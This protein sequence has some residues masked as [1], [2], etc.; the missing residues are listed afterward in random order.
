MIEKSFD[1]PTTTNR[2]V[3]N[4]KNGHFSPEISQSRSILVKDKIKM[5]V[6]WCQCTIFSYEKTIYDLFYELF[7]V[8]S[9]HVI[10][11]LKGLYGYD[12]CYSYKD[13][14]IYTSS[15]REDMGIHIL[16]SGT[17]C[18]QVEDLKIGFIDLFKKIRQYNAHYTRLDIAI[19][20]FTNKY[21]SMYRVKKS[22]KDNC[23]VS[24]FRNTIEFIKTQIKDSSNKGYTI[25]F[26]SRASDIQIVFYDKLKER[27]SQN[28]I[29][30]DNI[31]YWCRL[32]I[33]FRNDYASQVVLNLLDKDFNEYIKS[34]LKN[35][36]KFVE[37][38]E[39]EK[40][41]SRLPLIYWWS[42]FLDNV[43][44]VRL[45]NNNYVA[46]I[47]KKQSWLENS[48]ART[49]AMVLLSNIEDL[50]LDMISCD[51]LV[52]YFTKGFIEIEQKDIDYINE[53]RIKNGF[54]PIEIEDFKYMIG[55]IKD[56]LLERK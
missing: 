18:R 43:N 33:R 40:N 45:Y 35:Y 11:E 41:R 15:R 55:D 14:K 39:D 36:I 30:S 6:D 49:N 50:S 28:Q 10:F 12:K 54:N 9:N 2:G 31:K 13:I 24:R 29:V 48:T 1:T 17:G 21:F 20:N 34:I 5:C 51:Y 27:E 38:D 4:T 42:D 37:L 23:V 22:I 56:F 47:S 8:D 44:G 46:S 25:W 53:Y 16:L 26:G 3:V 19:D 7:N 52:K 32:E